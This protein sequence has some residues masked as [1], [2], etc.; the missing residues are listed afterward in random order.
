VNYQLTGL[1]TSL[2]IFFLLLSS[3]WADIDVPPSAYDTGIHDHGHAQTEVRLLTEYEQVRPGDEFHVGVLFRLEPDWHIY[4]ENPGDAGLPTQIS[5]EAEGLDI[6]DLQWSAPGVYPEAGGELTTFGYDGEVL[7]FS[8][9]VVSDDVSGP[10]ELNAKVEYLACR[11]SCLQDEHQ[12]SRTITVGDDAIGADKEIRRLFD[13]YAMQ[14]PQR[15]D[16]VGIDVQAEKTGEQKARLDL[17]LCEDD[18]M[19]CPP[20]ELVFEDLKYAFV[21]TAD[22]EVIVDVEAVNDH[23]TA[24]LGWSLEL[25]LR[26]QHPIEP[27]EL[28]GVLR[29][30][31]GYGSVL[32]IHVTTDLLDAPYGSMDLDEQSAPSRSDEGAP[33]LIY[34][35]LFAFLGGLIL[36][37]MPC[38]FP[39]LAIKVAS[40][41]ELVQK[42]R[43]SIFANAAAYTGGITASMLVL[44][45]AVV[46]LQLGGTQ[47]GWG[48]QFQQP[49]FL[50]ALAIIIV[51][52]ALN[53]FDVFQ[54]SVGA[55][56]LA[57]KAD[58]TTGTRRSFAE[59]IL[60]VVLA[61]PCSAPFLG[62]AVGF[63]LTANAATILLVFVV[64][65]LGLASPFVVLTMIPGAAKVLPKPGPWMGHL[66]KFLGFALLAAAI[67]LVWLVGR[68]AGVDAMGRVLGFLGALSMATWLFGVVQYRVWDKVKS[69]TVALAITIVSLGAV[70]TFP[71][72]AA[73]PS[74]VG[75]G[76]EV[77]EGEIDW[78]HWSPEAVE[79]QLEAGR[80]VFVDFTAD[81]CLTCQANLR[82]AIDTESVREAMAENDVA[83]FKADWTHPDETIRAEI[84][85]YGKAGVPMYLFYGPGESTPELLPEVLTQRMLI[86]RFS[87]D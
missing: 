17:V 57:E 19:N 64:L 86:D 26:K 12:L 60:A 30:D 50:V 61:T 87:R 80:P 32:P 62:T 22:S 33:S 7:L 23:P 13:D 46:G 4:W 73:P 74:A 5:W 15:A 84:E 25:N 21:T 51:L 44:G 6:K 40:F 27:P 8:R 47:V 75:Q 77:A 83:M 58:S 72:D 14:I 3:A 11:D 37:L 49:L 81:W 65:G 18:S 82:N 69:F 54:V 55:G 31:D 45:L 79:A 78:L 42:D 2:F 70:L 56:S 16:A 53:T 38:V 36:N 39:V 43:Q 76:G 34:I 52:F 59:G 41:T 68:L 20:M 9:A 28:S 66:K 24:H 48:F 10:I 1:L 71:V 35:L 67:W 29:L 63:A 85:S